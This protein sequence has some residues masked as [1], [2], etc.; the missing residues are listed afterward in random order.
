MSSQT[1][2][3]LV[4]GHVAFND[5]PTLLDAEDQVKSPSSSPSHSQS[6]SNSQTHSHSQTNQ[7]PISGSQLPTQ[8]KGAKVAE[9]NIG[10]ERRNSVV[11]EVEVGDDNEEREIGRGVKG[12]E[13]EGQKAMKEGREVI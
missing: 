4:P 3:P 6:Q 10:N 13:G 2:E 12:G 8:N 1:E 7:S 5:A 11:R 9:V